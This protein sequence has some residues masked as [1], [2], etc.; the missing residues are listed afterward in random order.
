MSR[1][2]DERRWA[3]DPDEDWD[4]IED[5]ARSYPED[6]LSNPVLPLIGLSD[7]ERQIRIVARCWQVILDRVEERLQTAAPWHRE[8][9]NGPLADAA[10]DIL[11]RAC[12]TIGQKTVYEASVFSHY[13]GDVNESVNAFRQINNVIRHGA[14]RAGGLAGMT[15]YVAQIR[16]VLPARRALLDAAAAIAGTQNR[17]P[18]G[19][20]K[21]NRRRR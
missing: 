9:F 8:S 3:A 10:C 15:P 7:P 18:D 4:L 21:P 5:L 19:P 13:V 12:E 20:M 11:A 17:W 6:V 16:C 2:G 1:E 14:R